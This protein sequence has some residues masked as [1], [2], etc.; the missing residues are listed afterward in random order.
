MPVLSAPS[1]RLCK[2]SWGTHGHIKSWGIFG[3]NRRVLLTNMTLKLCD[4]AKCE[5]VT[6]VC[7]MAP[8]KDVLPID[9]KFNISLD[10][11]PL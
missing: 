5:N 4:D 10:S 8:A 2:D 7:A 6:E 11:Y 3:D 9:N 1:Q